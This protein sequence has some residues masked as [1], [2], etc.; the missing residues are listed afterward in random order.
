[1]GG[2]LLVLG[3]LFRAPFLILR[4]HARVVACRFGL[5][6]SFACDFS[7]SSFDR[8]RIVMLPTIRNWLFFLNKSGGMAGFGTWRTTTG[9]HS[10][11]LCQG[12]GVWVASGLRGGYVN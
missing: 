1:M 9:K 11:Y 12:M 3:N 4:T 6:P 2:F 8:K 7:V 5:L 10:L